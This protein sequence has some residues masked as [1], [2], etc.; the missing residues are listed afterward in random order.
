MTFLAAL[1]VL[2]SVSVALY[3]AWIIYARRSASHPDDAAVVLRDLLVSRNEGTISREEFDAKQEEF[4]ASLLNLEN[5]SAV[6]VPPVKQL[7]WGVPL[8]LICLSVAAFLEFGKQNSITPVVPRAL[9][10]M[11]P[12]ASFLEKSKAGTGGDLQAMSS[13]LSEKMEKDPANGD[14]WLL[15]AR[16]Y[17]ELRQP[18]EASRAYAR[19]AKLLPPDAAMLADWADAYVMSHDRKWDKDARDIVKRALATDPKHLKALAL[20]GSEAFDRSD[21]KAAI[22]YWKRMKAAAPLDSMDAK[23]A[24]TNIEE[25]MSRMNGSGKPSSISNP[26]GN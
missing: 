8:I 5:T 20:A 26:P 14:G 18:L 25:A 24:D 3:L 11:G 19:A 22:D 12:K 4:Y 21:Y 16:T 17:N 9:E 13:R 15:L 2:I 1:F 23:L 10:T 7:R 6:P